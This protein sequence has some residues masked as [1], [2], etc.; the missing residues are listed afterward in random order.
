MS[1]RLDSHG[2]GTHSSSKKP[3][4]REQRHMV[5]TPERPVFGAGLTRPWREGYADQGSHRVNASLVRIE[6]IH[7]Y[8]NSCKTQL[9]IKGDSKL[10]DPL[11]QDKT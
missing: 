1:D 10:Q 4:C 5:A 6:L 8:T 9:F 3:K 2:D 11:I 7:N